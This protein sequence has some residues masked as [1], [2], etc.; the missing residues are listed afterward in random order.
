MSDQAH[1]LSFDLAAQTA[2][3]IFSSHIREGQ[4]DDL[5]R[6]VVAPFEIYVAEL[7]HE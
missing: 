5:S 2:R 4:S 3:L 1:A 6:L 7:D